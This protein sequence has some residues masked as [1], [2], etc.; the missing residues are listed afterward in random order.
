MLNRRIIILLVLLSTL[1]TGYFCGSSS[2]DSESKND[3]DPRFKSELRDLSAPVKSALRTRY[4]HLPLEW[5]NARATLIFLLGREITSL[6]DAQFFVDVI[7]EP[8]CLSLLDCRR[9]LSS[10]DAD[11]EATNPTT[12]AYPQIVALKS[13]ERLL[14]AQ[15]PPLLKQ[16]AA[17]VVTTTAANSSDALLSRR[18]ISIAQRFAL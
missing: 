6:E 17:A 16:F 8:Q 15:S 3:G 14:A 9:S 12:L 10:A 2:R 18:A 4:R 7:N 11:S 1:S 13:L 5:R